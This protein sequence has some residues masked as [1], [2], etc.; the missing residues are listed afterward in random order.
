VLPLSPSS[1]VVVTGPNADS[2][3]DTLGGWSVSWQGV[4][5]GG[6]QTCCVGPPD[7]IPPAVTVWKGIQSADPNAKSCPIRRAR[8]HR[9]VA[10]MRSSTSSESSDRMQKDSATIRRRS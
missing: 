8:S 4:Y 9:P 5:D 6:K 1:H 2:I 10:P 3:P 7:Q